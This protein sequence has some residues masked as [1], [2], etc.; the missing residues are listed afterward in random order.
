LRAEGRGCREEFDSG[1]RTGKERLLAWRYQR[2][3]PLEG[4]GARVVSEAGRN[5][6]EEVVREGES[7]RARAKDGTKAVRPSSV[8][9]IGCCPEFVQLCWCVSGVVLSSCSDAGAC[10]SDRARAGARAKLLASSR[11]EVLELGQLL[12]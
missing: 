2:Q 4:E 3:I 6:R 1:P 12:V 8:K 11:V 5:G 7:A 10:S 9:R